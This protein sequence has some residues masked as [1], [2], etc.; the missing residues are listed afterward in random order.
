MCVCVRMRVRVGAK[1]VVRVCVCKYVCAWLN[2][3]C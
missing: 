2:I 3:S 1:R